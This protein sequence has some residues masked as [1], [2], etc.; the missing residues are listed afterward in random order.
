MICHY[1]TNISH[2]LILL[3]WTK[4]KSV[5]VKSSLES[6]TS[7][8]YQ[9]LKNFHTWILMSK[10]RDQNLI[11]AK[12]SIPTWNIRP[13]H[14]YNIYLY[15]SSYNIRKRKLHSWQGRLLFEF[16]ALQAFISSI[17]HSSVID[18]LYRV[19]KPYK[20]F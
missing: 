18:L 4:Q 13:F 9:I 10:L 17:F 20:K 3:V 2:C 16:L 19:G 7:L 14:W 6:E 11:P 12:H 5:N 15:R 1:L 8:L